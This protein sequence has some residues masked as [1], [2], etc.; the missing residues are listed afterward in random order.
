MTLLKKLGQLSQSDR[1]MLSAKG[2]QYGDSWKKRGGVGAFMMLARK[3]DRIELAVK[4]AG[5]DVFA[6]IEKEPELVDDLQDLGCYLWLVRAEGLILE[7]GSGNPYASIAD[8]DIWNSM[9]DDHAAK[10]VAKDAPNLGYSE[11]AD[12]YVNTVVEYEKNGELV[13]K[14]ARIE[15]V[16]VD[17]LHRVA[18]KYLPLNRAIVVHEVPTLT[19]T[20]F[21]AAL[22][23]LLLV[24]TVG[25]GHALYRQYT[26]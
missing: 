14:E 19:Y 13:D 25:I 24:L 17:D 16:T 11:L 6:A 9:A 10:E 1:D 7:E 12:Y 2:Q 18:T 22:A 8:P 21:Y 15:S 20:Q 4:D 26:R 23:L 5:Y 3:W